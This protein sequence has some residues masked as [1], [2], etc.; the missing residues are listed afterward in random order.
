MSNTIDLSGPRGNAFS[1]MATAED[2]LRQLGKRG[3]SDGIQKQMMSGDYNNLLRVFE[4]NF[5]DYVT[6]INKPREE[7]GDE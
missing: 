3:E 6:L 7:E 2:L 5:G 1:L 4:E